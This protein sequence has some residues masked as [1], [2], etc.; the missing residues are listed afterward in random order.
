MLNRLIILFLTF[1]LM[2]CGQK[3]APVASSVRVGPD[4]PIAEVPRA[5]MPFPSPSP[6]SVPDSAQRIYSTADGLCDIWRDDRTMKIYVTA[7]GSKI[8]VNP[9]I[10]CHWKPV[11]PT[12]LPK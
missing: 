12:P 11:A 7:A 8:E 10:T 5:V 4:V 3:P 2:A 6:V 1:G 9:V